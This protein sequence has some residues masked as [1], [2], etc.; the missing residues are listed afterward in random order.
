MTTFFHGLPVFL[1]LFH[2][3]Y[4]TDS[5]HVSTIYNGMQMK[6][7]QESEFRTELDC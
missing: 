4:M 6:T 7:T 2:E 1:R 5:F 3:N